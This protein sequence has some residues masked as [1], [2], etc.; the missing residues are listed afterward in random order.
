MEYLRSQLRREGR[1]ELVCS[2]GATLTSLVL[3]DN[4]IGVT[5]AL[6]EL[7]KTSS[8][9]P[10]VGHAARETQ[11]SR[12]RSSGGQRSFKVVTSFLPLLQ[13]PSAPP[14][15]RLGLLALHTPH[16]K[17]ATRSIRDSAVLRAS[18]AAT[19]RPPLSATVRFAYSRAAVQLSVE[20]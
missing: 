9:R 19:R 18:W 15:C 17:L 20:L 4:Q 16:T 13:P 2:R 7:L 3:P 8:C 5:A 1:F 11:G 12:Q 6:S 10:A 14:G